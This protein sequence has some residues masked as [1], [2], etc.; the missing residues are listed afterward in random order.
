MLT[1]VVDDLTYAHQHLIASGGSHGIRM[2]TDPGVPGRCLFSFVRD[3]SGNWI[4]LCQFADLSGPLPDLTEPDPSMDDFI[5]FRD[6]GT[7]A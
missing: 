7:S 2:S 4:E 6:H 3:P 5:A 1:L